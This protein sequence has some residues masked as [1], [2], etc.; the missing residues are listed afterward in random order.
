MRKVSNS[1]A[2]S[3]GCAPIGSSVVALIEQIKAAM[4]LV[5]SSMAERELTGSDEDSRH[6]AVLDDVTPRYQAAA[7][8]ACDS[9]FEAVLNVVRGT[10]SLRREA[11]EAAHPSRPTV[12]GQTV[13]IQ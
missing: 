5:E 3:R 1:C 8:Q 4:A 11:D 10:R 13:S 7:L 9:R 6:F 12:P 2:S